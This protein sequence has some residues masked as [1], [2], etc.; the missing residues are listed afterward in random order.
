MPVLCGDGGHHQPKYMEEGSGEEDVSRSVG[1]KQSSD[2]NSAEEHEE[3]L[4]TADPTDGTGRIGLQLVTL[5]V[6]L[7][8][9]DDVDPSYYALVAKFQLKY[10]SGKKY[11]PNE[12]NRQQNPPKTQSQACNPPSG[13]DLGS[14]TEMYDSCRSNLSTLSP[15]SSVT[16]ASLTD[17][18]ELISCFSS[19][20]M[21]EASAEGP[22]GVESVPR[23]MSGGMMSSGYAKPSY[24]IPRG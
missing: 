4:Q 8:D 16:S 5:V 3:C 1:I 14:C 23:N 7:E 13:K 2:E 11:L 6:T 18:I 20:V 22:A 24:Q 21:T 12:Q 17:A 10:F 19:S 15:D 9:T